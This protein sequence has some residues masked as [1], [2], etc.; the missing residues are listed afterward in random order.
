[1]TRTKQGFREEL[2][3]SEIPHQILVFFSFPTPN[4]AQNR[5]RLAEK[6]TIP[7]PP[8][9]VPKK[10]LSSVFSHSEDSE[11]SDKSNGQHPEVKQEEDLHIS[12]MKRRYLHSVLGWGKDTETP[13]SLGEPA[14]PR[15]SP[16]GAEIALQ[17]SHFSSK[18]AA[19]WA[20]FYLLLFGGLWRVWICRL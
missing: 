3:E 1:M 15:G 7:L 12:I 20:F 16:P 19:G 10:E 11:E 5:G 4:P 2:F 14:L 6:R 18:R 17:M 9:R 8:T 13:S